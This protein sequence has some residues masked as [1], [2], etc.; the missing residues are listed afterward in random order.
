[1]GKH[2]KGPTWEINGSKVTGKKLA[3]VASPDANA[4]AWLLLEA[5]GE[6]E[7]SKLSKIQRVNTT[8]GKAPTDGNT[9]ANVGKE[10][11]VPYSATYYFY[12]PN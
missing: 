1:M 7:L 8:G 11:R 6:G 3:E 12:A 10:V 5:H 4:V 9:A 2:S